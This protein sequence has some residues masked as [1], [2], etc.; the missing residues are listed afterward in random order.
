M[1]KNVRDNYRIYDLI[2]VKIAKK[3]LV[4][5]YGFSNTIFEPPNHAFIRPC[6]ACVE[7]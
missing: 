4:F 2:I 6:Y 1:I 7:P 5:D 3:S